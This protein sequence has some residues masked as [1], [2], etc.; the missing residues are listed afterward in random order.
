MSAVALRFL[1]LFGVRRSWKILGWLFTGGIIL[2]LGVV[3]LSPVAVDD[4]IP[5]V[6]ANQLESSQADG[7]SVSPLGIL[8]IS[9]GFSEY[10]SQHVQN[11]L[12]PLGGRSEELLG[13][14]L[15]IPNLRLLIG[16]LVGGITL[17]GGL[18]FFMGQGLSPT[19]LIFEVGYIGILILWPWRGTRFL[20]P[21]LPFLYFQFFGGILLGISLMRRIGFVSQK[22]YRSLTGGLLVILVI[23]V[24]FA[25]LVKGITDNDNSLNHTRDLRIGAEWITGHSTSDA[26]VMAE[27]PQSVYLYSDRKTIGFPDN[28]ITEPA[29]LQRLVCNQNVK[30]ILIA[31]KLEWRADRTLMYDEHTKEILKMLTQLKNTSF[32]S[33]A[34][35]S[36]DDLV[37]VYEVIG[38]K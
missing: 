28:S 10:F 9:D 26:V 15:G 34:Y 2:I 23:M 33:L 14:Y 16:L 1:L 12:I 38:C 27:Q 25:S 17:F 3:T 30:F 21:I 19:V 24:V 4:L 22:S 7:E 29:Q 32:L 20:Y 8:R 5:N 35:E 6:Y 18:S 31:P 13:D 37:Q 36:K 11:A